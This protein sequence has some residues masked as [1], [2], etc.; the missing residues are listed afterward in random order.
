MVLVI[1]A[2]RTSADLLA[3]S[4]GTL[5]AGGRGTGP[6]R[7]PLPVP[8]TLVLG[9]ALALLPQGLPAQEEA[10][11]AH[12]ERTVLDGVFTESQA[13]RGEDTFLNNCSY[14]H[15]VGQFAGSQWTS[16][17]SGTTLDRFF[18]LIRTTM[19]FDGPGRL[20]DQQYADVLAYIL[21]ENGFPEGDVELAASGDALSRIRVETRPD[22]APGEHRDARGTHGPAGSGAGEPAGVALEHPRVPPWE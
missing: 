2:S 10:P 14:C 20:T 18:D 12:H 11:D 4:R 13:D 6:R 5:A 21:S 19:P 16:A 15:S 8:A 1:V 9:A 17:W 7:P 22:S 3:R